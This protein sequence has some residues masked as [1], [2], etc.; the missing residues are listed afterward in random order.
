MDPQN[1]RTKRLG[2]YLSAVYDSSSPTIQDYGQVVSGSRPD[3]L[4]SNPFLGQEETPSSHVAGENSVPT[5][6]TVPEQ[7]AH[8][9][10][11]EQR[12][13][14]SSVYPSSSGSRVGSQS[15]ISDRSDSERYYQRMFEASQNIMWLMREKSLQIPDIEDIRKYLNLSV[16][17]LQ[18]PR[19]QRDYLAN[20]RSQ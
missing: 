14:P 19:Y 16:S 7:I 10:T 9:I 4:E 1:R 3:L 11:I 17:I 5:D 8:D 6:E 12:R 2:R 18:Y 13:V 15:V 20:R